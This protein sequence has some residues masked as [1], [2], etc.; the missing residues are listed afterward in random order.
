MATMITRSGSR[1][2]PTSGR[3]AIVRPPTLPSSARTKTTISSPPT[4][5]EVFLCGSALLAD[6]QAP[7]DS[8]RQLG[9]V[10]FVRLN[11]MTPAMRKTLCF[12]CVHGGKGNRIQRLRRR[13]V[14]RQGFFFMAQQHSRRLATLIVVRLPLLKQIPRR[15]QRFVNMRSRLLRIVSVIAAL[16]LFTTVIAASTKCHTSNFACF[17]RKMMPKMGHKITVVGVLA[18]AKLH[19]IVRFDNWG[20]YI[21]A[22]QDSATSKINPLDSFNGQT[23]EATGILRY[24]P[25]SPT[26]RTDVASVPEHFFFDVAAVKVISNRPIAEMTFREM[27]WRKPPLVELYFDVVL[28]NDRTEPLWVLLPSNLGPESAS[29]GTKG[30]VD[31]VEVI[32]PHGEGR[33]I[34]GHF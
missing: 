6:D 22:V 27:R 5:A 13:G 9:L 2:H 29:V 16:I 32:A 17:K 4:G 19:S 33:V 15:A 8:S 28:H 25:G 24:S 20:V 12:G 31:G 21:Y 10:R 11:L 26:T 14:E 34:I 23:I 1:R 7:T 3:C 18:S 30:G